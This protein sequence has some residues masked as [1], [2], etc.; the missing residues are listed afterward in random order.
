M[1]ARDD[2]RHIYQHR[3]L[4]PGERVPE[5]DPQASHLGDLLAGLP[6]PDDTA[7]ARV[8]DAGCGS[9]KY[10]APLAAAG[11]RVH[12][13]DLFRSPTFGYPFPYACA[14]LDRLPFAD[15]SFDAAYALS[16][17]YYLPAPERA[18]RELARVLVP[19]G[20][21]LITAHTR[22]SSF[23]LL[24]R[25]QRRLG[26]RRAAHLRGVVFHSTADYRR[27]INSA[28]LRVLRVDGF[29]SSLVLYLAG[30][31]LRRL[32]G[33]RV[34]RA[35]LALHRLTGRLAVVR[36]WRSIFAYHCIFLAEKP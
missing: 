36:W 14:T 13:I 27:M 9:G 32:L 17:I 10:A 34:D 35:A 2:V 16:M 11:Y 8:L 6:T 19:G 12:G 24:R 3:M 4:A 23:T 31:A 21:V 26:L 20:R 30:A 5:G 29:R 18:L 25:L 28:G 33:P 15:A 7:S 1:I 22:H